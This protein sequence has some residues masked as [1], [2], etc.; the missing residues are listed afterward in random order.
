MQ[1]QRFGAALVLIAALSASVAF[2]AAGRAVAATVL[3]IV[4]C[5]STSPCTGGTNTSSGAGVQGI[6]NLGKGV[7][8]QTKF[9]STTASNG[10]FGVYGQDLS[11]SGTFDEGVRGTSVRG[12]GVHGISSSRGGV[13][14]DSTTGQGVYGSS[15]TLA[16]VQGV[17]VSGPGLMGQSTSTTGTGNGVTAA[18]LG[19]GNGMTAN[20]QDGYGVLGSAVSGTGI[21]A[22]SSTGYGIVGLSS[23]GA[24]GVYG[25][26]ATYGVYGFGGS[27]GVQGSSG[28]GYGVS[29]S[30]S[31]GSGL[32]GT[33]S[34]GYAIEGEETNGTTIFAR[35]T[36]HVG[37]DIRGGYAGVVAGGGSYPLV[38]VTLT[39]QNLFWVDSSGGVY[40]HNGFHTFAPVNG[41]GAATAFSTS[42]AAPTIEDTGS[43]RLVNGIASV[44]L[45]PTF[46]RAVDS[47]ALYHVML[48]PDGD[49]R[50]LFVARKTPSGFVVRETMGGRGTLDFDY[51]IYATVVGSSGERMK[52]VPSISTP[53]RKPAPPAP[54]VQLPHRP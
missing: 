6:S 5:A 11:T 37:A 4:T 49:T 51:H 47:R 38:A 2:T 52:L 16:G 14:G 41:G 44:S 1:L 29:G 12:V 43:A 22:T 42:A 28:S 7:I 3:A 32:F 54:P 27:R 8:A 17:S 50:G 39:G 18:A 30:S 46:A 10:Q 33:S 25:T 24:V 48:T 53:E 15:S 20:A 21:Y 26:A 19:H 40:A 23:T 45:D 9:N 13:R 35:N 34:S 36:N 31:S